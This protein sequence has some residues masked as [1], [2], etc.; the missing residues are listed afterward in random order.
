MGREFEF[1]GS[2]IELEYLVNRSKFIRSRLIEWEVK[3]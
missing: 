3:A 2:Q 1:E